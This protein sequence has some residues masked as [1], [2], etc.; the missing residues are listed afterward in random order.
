[1][2]IAKSLLEARVPNEPRYGKWRSRGRLALAVLNLRNGP[3]GLHHT[4]ELTTWLNCMHLHFGRPSRPVGGFQRL[5]DALGQELP[6][7]SIRMH[8]EVTYQYH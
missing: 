2:S 1:M 6:E 4:A 7:T 3:H 8:S 5:I